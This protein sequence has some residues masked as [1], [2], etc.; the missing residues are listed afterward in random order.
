MS[1]SVTDNGGEYSVAKSDKQT[2][3]QAMAKNASGTSNAEK[4]PGVGSDSPHR[5]GSD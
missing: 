3:A 2:F 5:F 1:Q 4:S